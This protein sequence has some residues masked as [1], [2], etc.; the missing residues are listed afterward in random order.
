VTRAGRLISAA[1]P[2]TLPICALITVILGLWGWL[3]HGYRFDNALYRAVALFAVN[4][5]IYRDPPGL[6][7]PRFMI[8]RWTGLL[9]V[10]GAALFALAAL[11]RQQAVVALAQLVRHRPEELRERAGGRPA[12]G[13]ARRPRPGRSPP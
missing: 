4:N 13:L 8:G 1:A 10:F 2:W 12:L 11:L 7:D 3:D 5:E 9:S 6:T